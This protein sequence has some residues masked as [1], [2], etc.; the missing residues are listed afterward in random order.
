[1]SS[2]TAFISNM[3]SP[4]RGC[5][6]QP[7]C[8][9]CGASFNTR[10]AFSCAKG[11]LIIMH[12]KLSGELCDM[13]SR[14]FQPSAVRDE[15]KINL[16]R[17]AQAEKTCAPT[18]ENE[19][20]GDVLIRGPWETGTKCILDVRITD[21]NAVHGKEKP[22]DGSRTLSTPAPHQVT[23][24]NRHTRDPSSLLKISSKIK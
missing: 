9:G 18:S 14:A 2:V 10:H 21:T 24:S 11:G 22:K 17:A 20:R 19:N 13:A 16:S 5:S 7:T 15:P 4:R 3:I 12:T 6:L 23:L 8:D 1:M